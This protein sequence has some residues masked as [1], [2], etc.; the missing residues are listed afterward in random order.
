[1][2][3]APRLCLRR[4][5]ARRCARARPL[6]RLQAD[7]QIRGLGPEVKAPLR[8][9]VVRRRV[10][11][12]QKKGACPEAPDVSSVVYGVCEELIGGT[13]MALIHYSQSQVS[14]TKGFTRQLLRET[15]CAS[16]PGADV[17][18]VRELPQR[19]L[20][21]PHCRAGHW[22]ADGM[23]GAVGEPDGARLLPTPE[24]NGSDSSLLLAER[25]TKT[26]QKASA[27][28]RLVPC[29]VNQ[30]GTQVPRQAPLD[31]QAPFSAEACSLRIMVP[32]HAQRRSTRRSLYSLDTFY[33]SAAVF[34]QRRACSARRR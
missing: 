14:M 18:R 24:M 7:E 22:Q 15:S 19:S 28:I 13:T 27:N 4:P 10:S 3:P 30:P 33:C 23:A 12:R 26:P 25:Q 9:S 29:I 31:S 6:A 8:N 16:G 17:R 34:P 20:A 21:P 32:A 5:H 2:R 1:M 11:A